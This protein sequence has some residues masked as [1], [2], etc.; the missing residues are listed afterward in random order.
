M[1][2]V[3]TLESESTSHFL[4]LQSMRN[5]NWLCIPRVHF[6]KADDRLTFLLG[7][8]I[9]SRITQMARITLGPLTP[10]DLVTRPIL[11]HP[12]KSKAA[13]ELRL[14]SWVL[15][16]T[17]SETLFPTPKSSLCS[18]HLLTAQSSPHW[19]GPVQLVLK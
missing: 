12:A 5:I 13:K 1:S 10:G 3:V 8:N 2:V 14:V 15:S 9:A 6:S 7:W 18:Y 4:G 17:G 19:D 11:R 16:A